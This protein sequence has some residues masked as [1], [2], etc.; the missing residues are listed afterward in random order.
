MNAPEIWSSRKESNLRSIAY[1]ASAL[2]LSY[3]RKHIWYRE[4]GSNRPHIDF[5][6]TALPTELSRHKFSLGW[7]VRIELT[8]TESQS[9]LLPLQHSHTKENFK[10]IVGWIRTNVTPKR[11][12]TTRRLRVYRVMTSDYGQGN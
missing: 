5:Q 8:L 11:I 7:L 4:T 2:P 1:Q 10:L 9:V 12:L 3:K 6:S